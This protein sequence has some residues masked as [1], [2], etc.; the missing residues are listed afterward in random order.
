MARKRSTS[1]SSSLVGTAADDTFTVA[2]STTSIDGQGGTNTAI[3]ADDISHY[4][5]TAASAGLNVR[6][7]VTGQV[8]NVVNVQILE[9]AG[10]REV[11]YDTTGTFVPSSTGAIIGTAGNDTV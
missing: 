11:Y 7:L 4:T 8:V 9:F 2:S 10:G 1:T 6:N 5:V 3:F